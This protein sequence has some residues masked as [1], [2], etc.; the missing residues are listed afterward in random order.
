M[1]SDRRIP[2]DGFA[3]RP[4]DLL[5]RLRSPELPGEEFWRSLSYALYCM[6]DDEEYVSALNEVKRGRTATAFPQQEAT[7]PQNVM[8][9]AP[10]PFFP[11]ASRVPKVF[12]SNLDDKPIA[13]ALLRTNRLGLGP[14]QFALATQ[15]FFQSIGWLATAIDT[16]FVRWMKAREIISAAADTLTHV[17]RK[18]SMET[19]KENLKNIF[20]FCNATGIWEDKREYYRRN[21]SQKIND[22]KKR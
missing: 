7:T 12:H 9:D 3:W 5:E 16:Q 21:D 13:T 10:P 15:E 11:P 6:R 17:H 2:I 20:Q 1:E 18:D 8:P 14:K 19:L 4:E 22:G